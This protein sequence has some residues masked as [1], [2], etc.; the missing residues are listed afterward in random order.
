[1]RPTSFIERGDSL[2]LAAR[3]I[4][5]N[6]TVLIPI[7]DGQRFIGIVTETSLASALANGCQPSDDAEAARCTE[8][9]T[10][11]PH[12]TGAEAL[13]LFGEHRTPGL[14][15]ID[16]HDRILGVLTPSDLYPKYVPPLR[17]PLIGGMATPFGVYLST[18]ELRAGASQW[19]L[20]CTGMFLFTLLMISTYAAEWVQDSLTHG[21]IVSA[22]IAEGIGGIAFLALFMGLMRSLPL[23]GIHAAEHKVVH[24]I[25]RGEELTPE[26]V[27]RMPRVHPRCG[28]NIT[29][30]A[31]MF[32]LLATLPWAQWL[33]LQDMDAV[34]LLIAAALTLM[35]WRRVG[36][37][38]QR[39][40]TTREP[41]EK[42]LMMG[43]RS[44]R[45]L[46]EKYRT[47]SME[48][49]SVWKRILNSGILQIIAG[50]LLIHGIAVG[51]A[52]LLGV[53][54]AI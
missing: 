39:Y 2:E 46:L 31:G 18:G 5:E 12:A 52:S 47:S 6:G 45:E 29:A 7:A 37:I 38:L 36:S 51:I 41:S 53:H 27:R 30:G 34:Q 21:R 49:P 1:M 14:V 28:T 17:P 32:L 16:D 33:G 50:S 44:G 24:A 13:R 42:E 22:G 40:V 25:E 26:I 43:I 54:L 3:R 11:A 8:S 48:F 10:V 19:A 15:V 4:R 23:S 35:F 9:L 20:V